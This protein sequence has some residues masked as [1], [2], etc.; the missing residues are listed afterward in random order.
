MKLISTVAI[1][2]G[3][4]TSAYLAPAFRS[5]GIKCVHVLSS[6]SLPDRL[7]VQIIHSDYIR[8]VVYQGD[9]N[10]LAN[11][12]KDL[13][14]DVVLPGGGSGI[15]LAS[16]LAD[17]LDV[18][19]KNPGHLAKARR[20]KYEQI[21]ILHRSGLLTPK[22][23]QSDQVAGIMRWTRTHLI[24]PVVVKP[25][26]GAGV[27]GVKVCHTLSQVRE[28]S[29]SIL[30]SKSYY[31][32]D[33]NEILVQSCTE[34]Q[35]FIVDIVSFK[36]IHKVVSVWQVD[37]DRRESP[38][39]EK[40]MVVDHTQQSYSQLIDYAKKVLNVVGLNYGPSH[41]EVMLTSEG[42]VIVELNSRLHGSLDPLLTTAVTGENHVSATVN[43]FVNTSHF[44]DSISQD[45]VFSGFCG[46][47]LLV[48]P[49]SDREFRDFPWD[50]IENLPSFVSVK[51]WVKPGDILQVTTGLQTAIGMVGLFYKK[52][53][54][55]DT[56]WKEIRKIEKD[57]FS[58]PHMPAEPA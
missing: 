19:Y 57:Y 34:G 4:S 14:I 48:S 26:R 53:E 9:I 43:A 3:A 36:G 30:N 18:P 2:D 23:Y 15:E 1:V 47:I 8:S 42:P 58:L 49:V 54:Q 22:Q 40:M 16:E 56:D 37:R 21:E 10:V 25:T 12:L 29:E 13:Q 6:E 35:E 44:I 32:E 33:Q 45:P 20:H 11:M 28:A 39:L 46:H 55:L 52:F 50:R 27:S 38:R 51:R 41:M 17:T 24:L 5:Y 31:N 7:K